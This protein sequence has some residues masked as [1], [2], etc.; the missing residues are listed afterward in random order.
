MVLV[1]AMVASLSCATTLT[2][3]PPLA[4]PAAVRFV[5]RQ[6]AAH[7]VAVAGSFNSWSPSAH[8]MMREG[9]G[10]RWTAVV[11][12]PPG[13]YFFMFVVDGTEWVSPPFAE[14]YVD[15]GFGAKNGVIVVRPVEE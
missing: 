14:A 13:E 2:P 3:R 9:S 5:L 4:A 6:P 12:L 15:D 1:A 7:S 11:A 8:P 10:P